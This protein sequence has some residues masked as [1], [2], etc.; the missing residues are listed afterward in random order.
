M[1]AFGPATSSARYGV[2]VDGRGPALEA[3]P[4]LIGSARGPW[5]ARHVSP[6]LR[7]DASERNELSIERMIES[8]SLL[9]SR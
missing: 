9:I 6:L 2:D 4:P 8:G 7:D 1:A 5:I 3:P